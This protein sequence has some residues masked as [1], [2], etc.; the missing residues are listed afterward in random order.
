MSFSSF[1]GS[2]LGPAGE[3]TFAAPAGSRPGWKGAGPEA[4]EVEADCGDAA[5][6]LIGADAAELHPMPQGAQLAVDS[7]WSLPQALKYAQA[8]APVP[9]LQASFE[10]PVEALLGAP[11]PLEEVALVLMLP[12]GGLEQLDINVHDIHLPAAALEVILGVG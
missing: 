2:R 3:G 12:D 8:S 7:A 9:L 4:L 5:A 6:G 1:A 10:L 11:P